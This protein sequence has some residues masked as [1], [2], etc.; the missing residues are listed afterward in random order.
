[1][2]FTSGFRAAVIPAGDHVMHRTI[3][4]AVL[5]ACLAG[6]S[7]PQAPPPPEPAVVTVAVPVEKPVAD[8][9]DY[10]GRTDAIPS[11]DIRARVS[12]YLAEIKFAVGQPTKE[13]AV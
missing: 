7:A 8:Y 12:G 13:G 10:T 1:M 5:F 6:C 3:I 11:V 4:A 2:R 9:V